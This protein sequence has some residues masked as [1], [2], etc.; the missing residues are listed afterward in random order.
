MTSYT[1]DDYLSG[2]VRD[3]L[4]VARMAAATDPAYA[5]NVAALLDGLLLL[6]GK[7]GLLLVQHPLLFAVH[8][9]NG[10]VDADIPEVLGTPGEYGRIT[11]ELQGVIFRDPREAVA[12]DPLRGWTCH[13][14]VEG[15]YF[16]CTAFRSRHGVSKVSSMN[17]WI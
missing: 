2:N 3:K 1:A 8:I 6:L 5:V 9:L 13:S 10:V 14:A 16:T 12:D 11:E 7:G 17:C 15:E 4:M